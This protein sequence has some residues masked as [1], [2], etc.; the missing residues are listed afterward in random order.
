MVIIMKI[1]LVCLL[2]LAVLLLISACA[3]KNLNEDRVLASLHFKEGKAANY[4]S[5]T[6]TTGDGGKISSIFKMLSSEGKPKKPVPSV[7][8]DLKSLD[9]NE[10]VIIWFGHSSYMI[11][12]GGKRLLVDPVLSENASPIPFTNGPFEGTKIYEPDDIPEVD[13][14]IITHDHYDHLSKPTVKGIKKKVGRVICPLGVGKYLKSWGY[15]EDK[16]VEM[17]WEEDYELESGFTIYCVT[18]RHFSGRGLF[19]QSS[20]LWAAY[21][22]ETPEHKIYIGGDSGY[23]EHFKNQGERFGSVDIAFLENGQYDEGWAKIHMM[24]EETL[25]AAAALRTKYLVPVH[26]SKYKLSLHNWNTPLTDLT[27]LHNNPDM[28]L[29]TPVIGEKTPLWDVN[30]QYTRWWTYEQTFAE[31]ADEQKSTGL[32]KEH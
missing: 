9:I 18:A 22:L 32:V 23:G 25:A 27:A 21:L 2:V 14:M 6:M 17:D 3:G 7:K 11:Q 4:E 26:N 28:V 20:T 24:P 31:A 12:T 5:T 30:H 13:Y 10:E 16:I 19:S 1:T 8:T 29:V 15:P